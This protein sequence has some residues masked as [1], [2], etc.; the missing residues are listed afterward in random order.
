MNKVKKI[1]LIL[2]ILATV[3]ALGFLGFNYIKALTNKEK[4]P[5]VSMEIEGYGTVKIELYP[6]IAPNTVKNFITLSQKGFYN[7][8]T[9]SEIGDNY[10]EGGYDLT[11]EPEE[12]ASEESQASED[13]VVEGA[14]NSSE[15]TEEEFI[16]SPK[17]SDIR[18]LKDGET[19]ASY[20]I[21]GEFADNDFD[22]NRLNHERGV[23][24]MAR[25]DYT[26]Y[27]EEIATIRLMGDDYNTT[28]DNIL[29]NMYDSATSGFFILTDN[30]TSYNGLYTAF[31]RVIEGMDIVDKISE[32]EVTAN[33]DGKN[34]PNTQPV[35]KNVSVETYGVNYGIPET[36]TVFD[37]DSIFNMFLSNFSS[38]Q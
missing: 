34:V 31:G 29:D 5:V 36:V 8:K 1:V 30:D 6:D 2:L 28:I 26:D 10:I 18:E 16:R 20:A 37:F 11:E 38:A 14:E 21:K 17:L 22:D 9:F 35:I 12:D 33:E 7:G 3:G 24:S 19:D 25:T 32:V 27:Q 23:I 13:V 15:E 4:N